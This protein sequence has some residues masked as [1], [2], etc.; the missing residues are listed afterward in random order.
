[1]SVDV[2]NEEEF[3]SLIE[4]I[5]A[6]Y[7]RLDAVIHGAGIIEDKLIADKTQASLDRV[8][9]TKVDST[10]IL[11]R[12]LRPD[13]LKAIILFSSVAGSLWQSRSI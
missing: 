4:G 11:S 2:R 9:D 10:F 7:G 13:S 5:Y 6:R 3:G 8:F 12:Y 1:L